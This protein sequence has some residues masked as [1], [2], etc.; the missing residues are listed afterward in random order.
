[1]PRFQCNVLQRTMYQLRVAKDEAETYEARAGR[2]LQRVNALRNAVTELF[3]AADCDSE[4]MRELL[5][6]GGVTAANLMQ[7]LGIVEQTTYQ[8]L[9]VRVATSLSLPAF[10]VG[11]RNCQ[12]TYITCS[13]SAGLLL[14]TKRYPREQVSSAQEHNASKTAG[15]SACEAQPR[16]GDPRDRAS[17]S[18]KHP[19]WT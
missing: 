5:G 18:A 2:A 10:D 9:Q 1:M 15:S 16:H 3:A 11:K 19:A 7:Y 8:L 13:T 6:S 4:I 12:S 14:K 17:V